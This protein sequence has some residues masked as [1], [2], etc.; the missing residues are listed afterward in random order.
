MNVLVI[1]FV[2]ADKVRPQLRHPVVGQLFRQ[3]VLALPL[4]FIQ[5]PEVAMEVRA[6]HFCEALPPARVL[7][8]D[9]D[10]QQ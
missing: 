7:V 8:R 3:P 2:V 9:L 10:A 4:L 6:G 5:V 1:A